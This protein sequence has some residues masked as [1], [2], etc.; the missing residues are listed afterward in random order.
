[1]PK[2]RVFATSTK[3]YEID[4]E[5]GDPAS[6]IAKLDEWIEDDFEDFEVNADWKLEAS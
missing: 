6:A 1:M 3:H 2:Y 5:A 4:V